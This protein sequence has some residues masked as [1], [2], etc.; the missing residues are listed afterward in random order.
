MLA[1]L[2]LKPDTPAPAVVET[3]ARV[4]APWQSLFSDSKVLSTSVVT[5]HII[6][7]LFGGGLAIAADR[8]TLR[9]ARGRTAPDAAAE[10]RRLLADLGAVHR[11]VLVA[12]A[13]LFV[14]GL[15]LAAADVKTYALAWVFWLKIGLVALLLVNGVALERA[16][17]ALRRGGPEAS[18]APYWRRLRAASWASLALWTATTVVGVALTNA[19]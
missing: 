7:L 3:L 16:E 15:L 8:A 10:E 12:L 4:C 13:L 5:V 1:A 19:A 2:L 11:P 17:S 6:A 14:S 18:T 9:V